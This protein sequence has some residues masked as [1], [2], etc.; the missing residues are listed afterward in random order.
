ML[1]KMCEINFLILDQK[2]TNQIR[3]KTSIAQ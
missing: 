1:E 2:Y 3:D